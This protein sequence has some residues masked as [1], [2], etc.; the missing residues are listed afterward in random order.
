MDGIMRLNETVAIQKWPNRAVSKCRTISICAQT[1]AERWR[2]GTDG[3]GQS[4]IHER[5]TRTMIT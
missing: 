3:W 4:A 1:E 2:A 5:R